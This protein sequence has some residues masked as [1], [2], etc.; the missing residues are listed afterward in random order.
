MSPGWPLHGVLLQRRLFLMIIAILST[1]GCATTG[2]NGVWPRL[3][4]SSQSSIEQKSVWVPLAVA[5]V[6]AS[7]SA[8]REVSEWAIEHQPVFGSVDNAI[9]WSDWLSNGV[10]AT[11]LITSFMRRDDDNQPLTAD[12][13]ALS[14]AYAFSAGIKRVADRTRPDNK[15]DLSFPSRHATWA[16]CGAQIAARNLSALETPNVQAIQAGMYTLASASA[17]ARI[18]AARH[19]PSDVLAG[20]AI[21]HFFAGT[22]NAFLENREN[23]TVSYVPT[24]D[25]GELRVQWLF[26]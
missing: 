18:E 8:D 22:A 16:F 1:S 6:F 17:W 23:I 4:A 15:D 5:A 2:E 3:V 14:S 10:V 25:G 13:L 11:A 12:A 26:R 21:G 7:T 9:D 20:A 24:Y 19:Y